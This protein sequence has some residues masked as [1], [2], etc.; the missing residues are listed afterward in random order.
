MIFEDTSQVIFSNKL[1]I[2]LL[3]SQ[4]GQYSSFHPV[5]HSFYVSLVAVCVIHGHRGNDGNETVSVAE[6]I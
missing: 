1:I 2:S 5:R 6:A 4:I 3:A